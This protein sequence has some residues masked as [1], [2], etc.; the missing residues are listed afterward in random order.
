MSQTAQTNNGN[1]NAGFTTV[2]AYT[3]AMITLVIGI[4]VGYFARGSASPST[5]PETAQAA[6]PTAT[7]GSGMGMSP[8][9]L[10][11]IGSAQQQQAM[12]P[13]MI[14]KAADRCSISFRAIPT[15]SKP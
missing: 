11:G 7:T 8:A 12:T 13:E 15:M 3:L 9:Q 4:A 14:A 5:A 2:Q 6:A 1:T 10:P